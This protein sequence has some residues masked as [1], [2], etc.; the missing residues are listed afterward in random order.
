MALFQFR[1]L[2]ILFVSFDRSTENWGEQEKKKREKSRDLQQVK[3][4]ETEIESERK[5]EAKEEAFRIQC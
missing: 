5:A 1:I 3:E 4:T 2:Y